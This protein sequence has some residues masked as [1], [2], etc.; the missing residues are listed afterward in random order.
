MEWHQIKTIELLVFRLCMKAEYYE[1]FLC[2]LK[3]CVSPIYQFKPI[4][5]YIR[6]LAVTS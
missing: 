5:S 4:N 1:H 2:K 3:K 6:K